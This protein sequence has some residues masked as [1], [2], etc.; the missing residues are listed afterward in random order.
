MSPQP[1]VQSPSRVRHVVLALTV[2]AYMIT[3]MDRVVISSAAPS[4]RKEFAFDMVTMSWILGSFRWAYSVFQIPGGWIGDRFGPR[5][6]LTGIVIWWSLCCSAI[7]GMWSAWSMKVCQFLFGMGEAGAFPT[8]TRSLSRWM[9]PSER[10]FAQGITHA[11]SRL[12]GAITPALVA[13]VIVH[14]GWR[15]AFLSLPS[16]GFLWAVVWYVYYRDLPAEHKGV[17]DAEREL[18][19]SAVGARRKAAGSV[20]W[21]RILGSSQMWILSAAY[22]CYG[23][24]LAF[25]LD[26]FPTYLNSA[27]GFSIGKMGFFASLTLLAGVFGDLGGGWMSDVLS[28]TRLGLRR[29]RQV[30][31]VSGFLMG[32]LSVVAASQAAD[33]VHAVWFSCTSMFFL[34][35]TVGVSWAIPLDIGG[36]YAGSVSGVMNTW[37]NLGGAVSTS[38]SGYLVKY[39]GWNAIFVVMATLAVLGAALYTRIDAEKRIA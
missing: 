6:A 4:I 5:R 34:E 27:R 30:V 24:S 19:E 16:L 9:L 13:W 11:G 25:Y 7:V 29:A 32:G 36:D 1:P 23:Y 21:K 22:F 39:F 26:L 10:G 38:A 33:P 20:P 28:R 14:F 17:N 18:I 8:A 35:L 15:A 37:G 31:A 12:G 3:Y 2:A